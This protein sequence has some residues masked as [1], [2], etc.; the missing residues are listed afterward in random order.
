MLQVQ[1]LQPRAARAQLEQQRVVE[2]VAGEQ[3]EGLQRLARLGDGRDRLSTELRAVA[4]GMW[5]V[6]NG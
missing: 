4:C 1:P 2:L 5:A 6:G 3:R